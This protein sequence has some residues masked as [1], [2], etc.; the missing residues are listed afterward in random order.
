MQS[1]GAW[2][3]DREFNAIELTI[4]PGE[5]LEVALEESGF[6]WASKESGEMGWVPCEYVSSAYQT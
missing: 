3:V 4:D 1:D 6:Y 5:I 2:K